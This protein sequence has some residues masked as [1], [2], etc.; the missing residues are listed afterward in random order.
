MERVPTTKPMEAAVVI[1]GNG[2]AALTLSLLLDRKGISHIVLNRQG[3]MTDQP[4]LA[5]TLPPSAIPLLNKTG[6]LSLF[7]RTALQK[8]N[9]YHSLWGSDK[10][11]DNN[12]YFHRPYQ[13]GLKID[14]QAIKSSLLA[15]QA[16]RLVPFTQNISITKGEVITVEW[17]E[18]D[19]QK[20]CN[21]HMIVDATGRNRSILAKLGIPSVDADSLNA[22]SCHLPYIKHQVLRHSVYI[23]SFEE[24]WG[25]V[26]T[27][28]EQNN[29]M[30]LFC[31]KKSGAQQQLKNYQNWPLMLK[32]TKYL[33]DFIEPAANCPVKGYNA[34]SSKAQRLTGSAWLA[35]GDAAISFDPLSSH[36]ITNAIYTANE[37]AD[38]IEQLIKENDGTAL[39]A[40]E[41]HLTSIFEQYL[42]ARSQI[43]LSE[44][45]WPQSMFWKEAHRL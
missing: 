28:N 2:I 25:I 11:A 15:M 4:A 42:K 13:Y 41:Q 14:K 38:A 33:K 16:H 1:V 43:Y 12:F 22:F 30:T 20:Q 29:V 31:N 10:V 7:E 34:N 44:Q 36:G 8:T 27:L 23:E 21:C 35:V 3:K 24:G 39:T 5:E 26:S 17:A 37:A 19:R 32:D 45:R 40:Y 6:L 9:G 18:H